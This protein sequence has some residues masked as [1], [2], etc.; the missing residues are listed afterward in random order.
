MSFHNKGGALSQSDSLRLIRYNRQRADNAFEAHSAL[1]AA[2]IM[3]P[4]LR[5]NPAWVVL[6]QD[7]YENFAL[8]FEEV[9]K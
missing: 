9:G 7:A 6:R 4:A 3:R 1:I 8:A 2:E 5:D